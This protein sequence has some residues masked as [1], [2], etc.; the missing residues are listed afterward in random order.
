MG[1][2]RKRPVVIEALPIAQVI[3]DA[4]HNW[5]GLP[6]WVRDAYEAGN[7]VIT[8]SEIHINTVEGQMT[9]AKDDWLI[10]GVH[11]ELYP[12]KPSIFEAT[13]EFIA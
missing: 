12:C 9:G 2:Y 3:Y 5:Q 4:T 7:I 13:Y 6:I 11:G 10:Q 8:P 1:K